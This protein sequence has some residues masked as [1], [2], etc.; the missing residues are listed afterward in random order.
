[1][2]TAV[3]VAVVLVIGVFGWSITNRLSADAIGMALGLGFGVLAGIPAALLVY[4]ASRR[5]APWE[6]DED[7]EEANVRPL[8]YLPYGAQPPVVIVASGAAQQPAAN[9]AYPYQDGYG[10][11]GAEMQPRPALP[12]PGHHV[13]QPRVF[14]MI[15]EADEYIES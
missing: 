5:R 12:G 6:E 8:G 9:G 11:A 7:D 4:V 2:K 3:L 14:R 13:G 1:M 15:G 10:Y